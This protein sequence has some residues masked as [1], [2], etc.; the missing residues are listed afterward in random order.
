M[1]CYTFY[2][3]STNKQ[4]KQKQ[5]NKD[6]DK[7]KLNI[8][9]VGEV[10][11]NKKPNIFI[12]LLF[13]FLGWVLVSSLFFS[14]SFGKEKAPFSEVINKIEQGDIEKVEFG[15]DKVTAF[16]RDGSNSLEAEI[17]TG[18]DFLSYLSDKGLDQK[19]DTLEAKKP[20]AYGESIGLIINI[21]F[22]ALLAFFLFSMMKGRGGAGDIL[23]FGKSKAKLF[24]KEGKRKITFGDVAVEEE[25]KDELYEVVDFLKSPK[26]YLKVGARIP[27]G[28][29]LVGPAGVGKTLVARAI[30]GEA[31]VPFYSAAGSEF[32]EMLVGVGSARV[33]DMFKT[34]AQNSPSLIFIDEIDAI[35]RQR[36]MGIGGG[37]DER[38]QTLNQILVE[39]DG[40]EKDTNVIVIAAT[41]RPDMLDPALVRPG[42]FD[43]KITLQL[44]DLDSRERIIKIHAK[45]KPFAK[46]VNFDQIAKRTVGFSGADI[47]NMLN[48]AAILAAR[49][50]KDKITYKNIS[51]AATKVKLGPERKKLQ[52]KD[53]K[54]K[55]AYHEAGHAVVANYLDNVD[56]VR[57]VSIVART[58]SLGHTDITGEKEKFNYSKD[59]LL[60]QLAMMLGGR[61]A[62]ELFN[63]EISTG[64]SNDIERATDYARRMVTEWGMGDLGPVNYVQNEDKKWLAMQLGTHNEISESRK[65]MIDE[66]VEALLKHAKQR[67][68]ALLKKHKKQVENVVAE[69][70]K[71]ETLEQDEFEKILKK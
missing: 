42:R 33:R 51:E 5:I 52:D 39:M 65:Q 58:M 26:K 45:G 50:N 20:F 34:A 24:N 47:E 67:A 19:V 12:V 25:I 53:E 14:S 54:K 64:A 31:D 3:M 62:D 70:M 55:T 4:Q 27:K 7:R 49:E 28:V 69:L 1:R 63:K 15:T 38:E 56:P 44:P 22:F 61:A 60:D 66:Q 59:Q 43:R 16:P 57:R 46:G 35:G 21:A 9:V 29:L 2:R 32:M 37:H 17:P 36:G 30:A 8:P 71:K 68:E 48:E 6:K 18:T 40:F 11:F 41:N 23:S 10:S 13:V